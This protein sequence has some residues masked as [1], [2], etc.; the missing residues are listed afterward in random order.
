MSAL[1]PAHPRLLIVEADPDIRDIL[2]IFLTE[3]GFT[4]QFAPTL[5]EALAL[6][7]EWVFHLILADLFVGRPPGLPAEARLLYR[8]TRPT[9]LGLMTTQNMSAKLAKQ[10]GFAFLLK[11]PF[12][13][14]QLLLTI[15][16]V[17]PRPLSPQQAAQARVVER[18][19]Q[20]ASTSDDEA[21]L[22]L[23]ADEVA[24][25]PPADSPLAT[26]RKIVGK[27]ALRAHMQEGHRQISRSHFDEIL[28]SGQPKGLAAQY[29]G[30]WRLRD[31]T[32]RRISGALLFHFEGE[33]ISQ[34][35]LRISPAHLRALPGRRNGDRS[36]ADNISLSV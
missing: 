1:A 26:T 4:V 21:A 22:M 30:R 10:Q 7:D 8:R 27:A 6:V 33:R 31:G 5:Q 17:L 19:L 29:R 23:C 34:I 11:K 14:E 35:G 32:E 16:T 36:E 2:N 13:L 28:I 24:Y 9:P 12:D 18:F 20:A 25:Y 3:E 15:T